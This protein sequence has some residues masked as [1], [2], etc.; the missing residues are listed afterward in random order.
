MKCAYHPEIDAIGACVNCGRLVC[1]ECK[2]VLNDKIYCNPCVQGLFTGPSG[3]QKVDR[4]N[5]F[6][7]HL[8]WTSVLSFIVYYPICFL[9]GFIL[10]III[11]TSDPYISEEAIEGIS[12]LFTF[13]IALAWL[14]P[15]HGWILKQ[16]KRRLWW[17]LILLVP[18]GWIV[19]LCLENRSN[20]SK[21]DSTILYPPPYPRERDK[22]GG[23]P[24]N[25]Y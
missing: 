23:L 12:Y 3:T 11:Y 17:L 16:K 7:R 2:T 22:G 20:R 21:R 15:I 4:P 24:Y 6:K 18:F 1:A 13:I 5:W 25:I 9:V 8:N 10:G 19:F 14:V